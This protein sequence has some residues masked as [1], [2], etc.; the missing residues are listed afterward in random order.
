MSPG[1]RLLISIYC[2]GLFS[3]KRVHWELEFYKGWSN[4]PKMNWS[5]HIT[6][7]KVEEKLIKPF[8]HIVENEPADKKSGLLLAAG[9]GE[10]SEGSWGE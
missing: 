3:I 7:I 5:H 9:L 8:L 6:I 10:R 1:R 4:W 2:P